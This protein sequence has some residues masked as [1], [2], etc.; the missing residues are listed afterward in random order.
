[1]QSP[2]RAALTD[3]GQESRLKDYVVGVVG[4]FASDSRVLGWDVW[5]EPSNTNIGSYSKLEPPDKQKLVETMLPKVFA[6]AREA[7]PSQPLTSGVWD[8]DFE[9]GSP[10]T[11]TQRTQLEE[12]DVVSFH[13]YGWPES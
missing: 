1:M 13:N 3:P 12:S 2:G 4:A 5:N 9:N 10:L 11:K 7:H 6:W 8:I